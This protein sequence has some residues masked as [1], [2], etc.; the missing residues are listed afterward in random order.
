MQDFSSPQG[1][2]FD[3]PEGNHGVLLIHGFTGSP[4]HM[5]PLGEKLRE[6]GFAVRGILLPGHGESPEALER[7]T[8]QDWFLACREAAVEMRDRYPFFSVA[9]LSMGGCLALMLAE[10]MEADAC[11]PIAA[12]MKTTARFRS[13][14][15]AAAL[16]HPM[17]HKRADGA[18]DTLMADYDIGYDS[19]PTASVGQLSAVMRRAKRDLSMI[20]CPVLTVQSRGDQTVTRDSPSII[21]QGVGSPVKQELWLESAP[22]V[23][24]ISPEYEKIAAGMTAFLRAAEKRRQPM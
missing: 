23:C 17:I 8:W 22:H 2:P 14:A 5:R 9:G 13:L 24:T 11:V 21:L 16:F 18:R 3:F 1:K 12:P 10:Q 15:P 6:A 20:R 7:V 19:Y 4:G